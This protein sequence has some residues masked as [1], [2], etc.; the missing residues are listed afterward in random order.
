MQVTI[1]FEMKKRLKRLGFERNAIKNP[2][3][4]SNTGD[5]V[6][7]NVQVDMLGC[8]GEG[9]ASLL[10]GTEMDWE[11]HSTGDSGADLLTPWGYG[12]VKFNHM[13]NGHL[14]IR[15]D[16]KKPKWF[17]LPDNVIVL[18]NGQCPYPSCRCKIL[19]ND[20]NGLRVDVYGW[21]YSEEFKE[22]CVE[23][24]YGKGPRFEVKRKL[25]RKIT[26]DDLV[27]GD[28]QDVCCRGNI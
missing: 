26:P 2:E 27:K 18:V 11:V 1:P 23:K 12:G 19:M 16:K 28:D 21:L 22:L 15:R 7:T 5:I 8:M 13:A 17:D 14:F 9:G 6:F 3:W 4:S 20:K 10:F 25:L 24:D